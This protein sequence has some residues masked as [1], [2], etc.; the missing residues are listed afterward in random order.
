VSGNRIQ[1]QQVILNLALNAFEAMADVTDRPRRLVMRTR[2]LDDNRVQVDVI[3]T[4]PGIA[5][6]KLESLFEPFVTSKANGMGVGLSVSRSIIV[7]HEGRLWAENGPDGGAVFHIILPAIAAVD[8][9]GRP[10]L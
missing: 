7:E 10:G 5:A 3:D 2:P 9:S 1:L 4:G 8:G 6:E